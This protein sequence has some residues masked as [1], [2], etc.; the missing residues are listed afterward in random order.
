MISLAVFFV[1]LFVVVLFM[2]ILPVLSGIGSFKVERTPRN[3]RSG[4]KATQSRSKGDILKFKL[5]KEGLDKDERN[6]E[7]AGSFRSGGSS[8]GFGDREGSLKRRVPLSENQDPNVFDFDV[9][10][11]IEEDREEYLRK[12]MEDVKRYN[13]N[14]Q[15]HYY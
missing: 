2:L 6:G 5:R 9:D 12:E 1:V 7:P 10:E 14:K 11:L 8:A 15:N 13:P 4:D 3:V